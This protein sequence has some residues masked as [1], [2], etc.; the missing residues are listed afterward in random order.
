LQ[1]EEGGLVT[2]G[3][4]G[5]GQ[6]KAGLVGGKE[7]RL[8]QGSKGRGGNLKAQVGNPAKTN[9]SVD[10]PVGKFWVVTPDL[11]Q[12]FNGSVGDQGVEDFADRRVGEAP[13][14]RREG[15][16][17]RLGDGKDGRLKLSVAQNP[18]VPFVV[19]TVGA[20]DQCDEPVPA[21]LGVG[22][23]RK[24]VGHFA[25]KAALDAIN[26]PSPLFLCSRFHRDF[27]LYYC[28][29][30]RYISY[31]VKHGGVS[32]RLAGVTSAFASARAAARALFFLS[33]ICAHLHFLFFVLPA[34]AFAFVLPKPVSSLRRFCADIVWRRSVARLPSQ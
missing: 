20:S 9:A 21:G 32:P 14:E 8:G 13:S 25:T 2:V 18:A 31:W 30:L 23:G 26:Q 7:A 5:D 11:L 19:A 33:L 34:L 12:D 29:G 28:F 27:A 15:A 16:D 4:G 24:G 22:G 6:P 3:V 17:F 10:K 1:G